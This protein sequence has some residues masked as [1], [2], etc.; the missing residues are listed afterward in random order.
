MRIRL[1]I[2]AIIFL[3]VVCICLQAYAGSEEA[4]TPE[5]GISA[6]WVLTGSFVIIGSLIAYIIYDMKR[7][8][9]FAMKSVMAKLD[10]HDKEIKEYGQL[11]SRADEKFKT[12]FNKL[13]I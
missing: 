4:I 1:S 13:K 5:G 11:H 7:Q 6:S 8:F 10:N 2:A 3:F 12:I 9:T